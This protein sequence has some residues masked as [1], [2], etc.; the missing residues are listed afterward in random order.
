MLSAQAPARRYARI[1]GA[2]AAASVGLALWCSPPSRGSDWSGGTTDIFNNLSIGT[3]NISGG[4]NTIHGGDS[5]YTDGGT[6]TIT[7]GLEFSGTTSPTLTLS[8]DDTVIGSPGIGGLLSLNANVSFTGSAGT[9]TIAN[10]NRLI[11]D[12]AGNIT[13]SGSVGPLPG[14]I[15]LNAAVRTFTIANGSAATDMVVSALITNGGLTKDGAGTLD[16]TFANSYT[17]VTTLTDGV[18]NVATIGN[19]GVAGNL[20]Q[21]ASAASNIVFNGG[22]LRYTG[23][24]ATS[25]RAFTINA[26]TTA[27]I[28][29]TTNSLSL[30]G[31]TGAATSGALTKIGNGTLILTGTST[32]TGGTVIS[33]G[34]LLANASGATGTGPVAV[35]SGGILGGSG[36]TGNTAGNVVSINSGGTVAPGD[37]SVGTLTTGE[38]AWMGGGSYVWEISDHTGSTPGTNWDLISMSGLNVGATAGNKFTIQVVTIGFGIDDI[39]KNKWFTVATVPTANLSGTPIST[40]IFALPSPPTGESWE[41]QAVDI[42]GTTSVQI[43]ATPEPGSLSLAVVGA[44]GLLMRRSRR[45]PMPK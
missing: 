39:T 21:A 32:Y 14:T 43:S 4:L 11:D 10:G 30:T 28:N 18:L 29:V 7:S 15:N 33:G 6:L 40:S 12:G 24:T 34:T 20:G 35:N 19:G 8:S 44:A 27:T 23:A 3:L 17:G 41:V 25:D 22:T 36:S 9:A 5:R 38:Q 37:N 42:G 13:N 45:T 2:A 1:G 16:L 26:A 31:A